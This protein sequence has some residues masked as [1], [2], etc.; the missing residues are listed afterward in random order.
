M[1]EEEGDSLQALARPLCESEISTFPLEAEM[2][3]RLPRSVRWDIAQRY[4]NSSSSAS[5]C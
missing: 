5:V 1:C 4:E 3:C 2:V